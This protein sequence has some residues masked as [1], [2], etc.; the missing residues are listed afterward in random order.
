ML[1]MKFIREYTDQV[2]EGVRL[3]NETVDIDELVA[4]D[5]R[6]RK[7]IFDVEQLKKK[8]NDNSAAVAMA[9]KNGNDASDLISETKSISQ[10]IKELDDELSRLEHDLQKMLA[11]VP[12]MPHE[13]VPQGAD[14]RDNVLVRQWGKIPEFDFKIK[15]HLEIGSH[16]DI[17]DFVRG[18]KITGSGFRFIKGRVPDW[19]GR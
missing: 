17:L 13:T 16:L 5:E 9:K 14:A 7:I 3:K 11:W 19:N 2:K 8:R 15:N 18:G 10:K 12:N 4:M 6:R 1:D